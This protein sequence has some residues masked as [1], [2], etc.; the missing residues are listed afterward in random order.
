MAFVIGGAMM[1]QRRVVIDLNAL[2][3]EAD[4]KMELGALRY[5]VREWALI[6]AMPTQE[7]RSA[8]ERRVLDRAGLLYGE[9]LAAAAW[10]QFGREK[11]WP[12]SDDG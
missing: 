4:K 5:I 10:A 6:P 1:T 2:R 3:H 11:G 9:V 12:I 8:A 7:L